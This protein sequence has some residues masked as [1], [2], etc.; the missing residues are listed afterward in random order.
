MHRPFLV[1][2]TG[3]YG[4]YGPLWELYG[5]LLALDY[6][7]LPGSN[8]KLHRTLSTVKRLMTTGLMATP[9]ALLMPSLLFIRDVTSYVNAFQTNVNKK[10]RI[11]GVCLFD[12]ETETGMTGRKQVMQS[13]FFHEALEGCAYELEMKMER[14]RPKHVPISERKNALFSEK[15][16]NSGVHTH[17]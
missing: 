5:T 9:V 14:L 1:R 7:C 11:K 16:A 15:Q 12:S 8:V 10:I 13:T 17:F 6:E 2:T 3:N 4:N